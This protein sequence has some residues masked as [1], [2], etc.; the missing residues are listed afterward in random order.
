MV[1]RIKICF[2][3]LAVGKYKK[4]KRN[5]KTHIKSYESERFAKYFAAFQVMRQTF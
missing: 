5:A 2:H 3:L 1:L 4:D